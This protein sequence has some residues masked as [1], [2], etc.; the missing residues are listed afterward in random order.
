MS[1]TTIE[2]KRDEKRVPV[3]RVEAEGEELVVTLGETLPGSGKTHAAFAME[4]YC[5]VRIWNEAGLPLKPFVC[6]IQE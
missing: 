5:E 6:E 1:G 4:P 3:E 2:I